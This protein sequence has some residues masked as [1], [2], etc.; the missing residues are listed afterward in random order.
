M[1]EPY[2]SD[3]FV[4]MFRKADLNA[5]I[6]SKRPR[7]S[8]IMLKVGIGRYRMTASHDNYYPFLCDVNLRPGSGVHAV[9]VP[10]RALPGTL[11]VNCNVAANVY[12]RHG[13]FL[14]ITGN[15]LQMPAG[16]SR[17]RVVR[18]HYVP[19]ERSV[20]VDPNGSHSLETKLERGKGNIRISLSYPGYVPFGL[21]RTEGILLVEGKPKKAK[22]PEKGTMLAGAWRLGIKL[23]GFEVANKAIEVRHGELT[24][25]DFL[26]TPK[27]SKIAFC[28]EAVGADKV[29][30]YIGEDRLGML[31]EPI[32]FDSCRD[33]VFSFRSEG[34]EIL[35]V[36]VESQRIGHNYGVIRLA[37]LDSVLS[38][39][40]KN[41]SHGASTPLL[42][43]NSD[44]A[45][46]APG[47][48]ED[49][50]LKFG[51][52]TKLKMVYVEPGAFAMGAEGVRLQMPEHEVRFIRPFWMSST[53]V[54]NKE[55]DFFVSESEY[56]GD[57][58]RNP[59]YLRHHRDWSKYA[60]PRDNFP[61]VCINR[62][63]AQ[64]FADWL[65]ERERQSRR[66]REGYV[67]RLPTEA[68]WEYA[69]GGG[70]VQAN[71][72]FS[73]ANDADIVAWHVNNSG[74]ETHAVARKSQNSIGL[75]DM[76]G[77]VWEWCV[78]D[79]HNDYKGAPLDGSA[80]VTRGSDRKVLR[81]GSYA[82]PKSTAGVKGRGKCDAS[83]CSREIGFRIVLGPE[84]DRIE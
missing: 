34:S 44:G 58:P 24:T 23:D 50:K 27:P 47:K 49:Y 72:K 39:L 16:T 74:E 38:V 36:P 51:F 83:V 40:N 33:A 62:N 48:A 46:Q 25:V 31:A 43:A 29:E 66:L 81:G 12:D 19:E 78:D 30:I 3:V 32:L 4:E 64:A 5:R 11:L 54:T 42:K 69:A 21:R 57:E 17:I 7:S 15:R 76:S 14:G 28:S 13:I 2:S 77:N 10:L 52:L 56:R 75:Y 8:V 41:H 84:Q 68:E 37:S 70:G 53:E 73:G 67:Y 35:S 22:F 1:I 55:Y 18:K 80:W 20:A 65:T 63:S 26:L 6:F 45:S 59:N 71:T 9:S 60:S 61:V 82:Q 79:W